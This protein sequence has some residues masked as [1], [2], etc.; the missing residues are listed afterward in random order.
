MR[1]DTQS[2]F[3][4][5]LRTK[6]KY[7]GYVKLRL[8]PWT[9]LPMSLLRFWAWEHLICVAVY[10]EMESSRIASKI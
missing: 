1:R 2:L 8:S 10:A 7:H 6:K 9:I 5:S 3:L 4:F